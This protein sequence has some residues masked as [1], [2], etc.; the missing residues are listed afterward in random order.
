[1][2]AS[3]ATRR[4]LPDLDAATRAVATEIVDRVARRGLAGAVA[5][6][7]KLGDLARGERPTLD[8]RALRRLPVRLDRAD[9]AA[10]ERTAA[11]IARFAAAQRATVRD[12]KVRSAY[13]TMG[14]R[15][16]PLDAAGCYAPGGRHPLPSSLLMTAIPARVAAVPSVWA[17]SPRPTDATLAA[18]R[19]ADVDGLLAIGGAQAIA[20]LALGGGPVP[21]SAIVAGP[22]N[23]YVAAAKAIVAERGWC[24]VEGV[25]GPSELLVLADRQADPELIAADLLA[26]AE[27][28]TDAVPMLVSVGSRLPG[29]VDAALRRRLVT[30]PTAAV[31]RR[32]LANGFCCTVRTVAEAIAV[33]DRIAPEHLEVH[34]ARP[35]SVAARCRRYGAIF[36][37]AATAEALGDYG[38]G[39]NHTLPTA[40]TA[41]FAAGLSVLDFLRLRTSL[42][43][44]GRGRGLPALAAD[45]IRLA[46]LEGLEAH[47]RSVLARGS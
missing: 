11:R 12:C 21:S 47:A 42:T 26:Q 2:T 38:A 34:T 44:R 9:A 43:V 13:G 14:H 32:A 4:V 19:I 45:A 18:A 27:H 24:A 31:A 41:R 23:R 5:V 33:A 7:R 22:G 29:L 1:V 36:V 30:L 6:A 15:V 46:R 16:M 40:G 17:A 37:G 39:P 25:A 3:A 28:D 10:L 35:A 20:L 8:R